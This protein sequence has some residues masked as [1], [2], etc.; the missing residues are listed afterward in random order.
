MVDQVNLTQV[1]VK[2]YISK[3][4]IAVLKNLQNSGWTDIFLTRGFPTIQKKCLKVDLKPNL[5]WTL[6]PERWWTMWY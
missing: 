5:F 2:I 1:I 3:V 6:T 4:K